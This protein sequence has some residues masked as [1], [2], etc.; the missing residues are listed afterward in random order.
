MQRRM[1]KE[2]KKSYLLIFGCVYA[3][4]VLVSIVLQFLLLP[5]I[6]PHLHGGDGMLSGS[7]SVEFHRKAVLYADKLEKKGWSSWRLDTGPKMS[8]QP[9]TIAG[10][11]YFATGI[12]EPWAVI[13]FNAF[14]HAATSIL[15]MNIYM[16]FVSKAKIA[17]LALGPFVL[18]P[19]AMAWY[20]Q[21][22]RDGIYIFGIVLFVLSLILMLEKSCRKRDFILSGLTCFTGA[23]IA[24]SMRQYS[25]LLVIGIACPAFLFL[26]I[27]RFAYA[28]KLKRGLFE[29]TG[30]IFL[31]LFIIIALFP[32][33]DAGHFSGWASNV[34]MENM[35]N[36][37]VIE[38]KAILP[39]SEKPLIPG[40]EF[41]P[42]KDDKLADSP[43]VEKDPN[44][45]Q[46]SG[47][48]PSKLD[49]V[50]KYASVR[51]DMFYEIHPVA[52]SYL[53][54]NVHFRS[55]LDVFFYTPRA[56]QV[57]WLAPFPSMWF[58]SGKN[59]ASE[60][61]RLI[62]GAEMAIAYLCLVG[63]IYSFYCFR[64]NSAFWLVFYFCISMTYIFTITIPNIGS[65]YRMRY[66][67]FTIVLGFGIL[68]AAKFFKR[69]V[70]K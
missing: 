62:S 36:V 20:A 70:R 48:L 31:N 45:W 61:Q 39:K 41:S 42:Q 3:G 24:W 6:L 50:I 27:Y 14:F 40:K 21:I 55:A 58:S 15:L 52:D 56:I 65:L 34:K 37:K 8:Q 4:V 10:A 9:V 60:K 23:M 29:S 44:A 26:L 69:F 67:C 49:S 22:H 12:R 25:L 16:R 17:L 64:K 43:E 47:F 28:L 46:K 53:D 51:R 2:L 68:G 1:D 35:K 18:F 63:L 30:K 13:P 54:R 38:D 7:D 32:L 11:I 59:L 19:S 66:G 33:T 57:G 5:K